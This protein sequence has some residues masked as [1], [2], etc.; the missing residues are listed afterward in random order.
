[1]AIF[2]MLALKSMDSFVILLLS[3]L[4]SGDIL[5]FL[6]HNNW[7]YK[8]KRY[9]SKLLFC[10]FRLLGEFMIYLNYIGCHYIEHQGFSV[11]RPNGTSDYL[12]LL[13]HTEVYISINGKK[14]ILKPGAIIIFSQYVRH[15]YYHPNKS[16]DHDWF[17]FISSSMPQFLSELH[18]PINKPFYIDDIPWIH[19]HIQSI[20]REYLMKDIYYKTQLN[21]LISSFF[22]I[23]SR[24][25]KSQKSYTQNPQFK[26]LEPK[27][28]EIR[29]IILTDLSQKWNIESMAKL[30]N[31]SSSRFSFLYRS[32]F[33]ISPKDDLLSERFNM[34][35]HL[36]KSSDFSITQVAQKVGYDNIYHFSKQFKKITFVSPV[37]YRKGTH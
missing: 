37:A 26:T 4:Q 11:N 9:I 35:R 29:S 10:H 3:F 25:K 21:N 33:G 36:L 13:F 28:K 12:F 19:K 2:I 34:A 16:F 1:M 8:L 27:F 6:T 20:E 17:H 31:L 24:I 23:L 5:V 18:L 32:F 22:I 14:E 30:A 15:N 7:A